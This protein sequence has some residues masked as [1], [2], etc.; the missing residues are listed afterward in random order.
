MQMSVFLTPIF[1]NQVSVG[2]GVCVQLAD[3][4]AAA[5]DTQHDL[6]AAHSP[7]Q[8]AMYLRHEAEHSDI[9]S[10]AHHEHKN[11]QEQLITQNHLTPPSTAPPHDPSITSSHSPHHTA[12]AMDAAQCGFCLLLGH[13]VLP[14]IADAP[15]ERLTFFDLASTAFQGITHPSFAALRGF[16]PQS[17][18]PPIYF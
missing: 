9:D 8:H 11:N 6:H 14:P 1:S 16:I 17:R 7:A 3:V 12:P 10:H 4:V 13:S 15:L 18:A 2:H 5:A